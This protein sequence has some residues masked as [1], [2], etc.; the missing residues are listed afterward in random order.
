V[1]RENIFMGPDLV[2]SQT[3]IE[4]VEMQEDP[5]ASVSASSRDEF[6]SFDPQRQNPSSW[7][8]LKHI[9]PHDIFFMVSSYS[10]V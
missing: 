1:I 4:W 10:V 5:V 3:V 8:E 6:T 9:L 2:Y 7:F